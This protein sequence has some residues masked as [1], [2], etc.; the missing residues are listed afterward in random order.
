MLLSYPDSVPLVARG[1][2]KIRQAAEPFVPVSDTTVGSPVAIVGGV[3][4]AKSTAI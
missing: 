2:M 1:A 4:D 3:P